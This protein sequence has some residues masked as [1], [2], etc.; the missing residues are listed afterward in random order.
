MFV[1]KD[2]SFF[3]FFHEVCYTGDPFRVLIRETR[4]T[5]LKVAT[6]SEGGIAPYIGFADWLE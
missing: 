5:D 2:S 1:N 4:G 6:R 3:A